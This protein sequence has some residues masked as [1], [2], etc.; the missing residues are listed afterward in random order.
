METVE[1]SVR[2]RASARIIFDYINDP[3]HLPAIWANVTH[4][5]DVQMP[6]QGRHRYHWRYKLCGVRFEGESECVSQSVPGRLTEKWRGGLQGQVNW[7]MTPQ[8]GD[9]QVTMRLEY[10]FPAP[11]T[12]KH[13]CEDVNAQQ[14]RD[15]EAALNNLKRV[16][17]A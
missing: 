15:V 3:T 12:H 6:S 8:N 7:M 10:T 9:T 5:Q 13:N 2:I 16:L 4:V 11:L 1:K 17:E 14:A